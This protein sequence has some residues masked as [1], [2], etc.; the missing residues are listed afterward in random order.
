M[1]RYLPPFITA[2]INIEVL[3]RSERGDDLTVQWDQLITFRASL[4]AK[5]SF[6]TKPSLW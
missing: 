5:R 6:R 2:C 1:Q 3:H 4:H